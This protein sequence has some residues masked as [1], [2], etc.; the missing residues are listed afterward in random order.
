MSSNAELSQYQ[1]LVEHD[2][3][4]EQA[5][6]R[7]LSSSS[8]RVTWQIN[9]VS[10]DTVDDENE[11]YDATNGDESNIKSP[12][13]NGS[14]SD[15][16]EST[17]EEGVMQNVD[18]STTDN[19]PDSIDPIDFIESSPRLSH[20]HSMVMGGGKGGHQ[21]ENWN[22]FLS[23]RDFEELTRKSECNLVNCVHNV[24]TSMYYVSVFHVYTRA[25]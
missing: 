24:F 14:V 16:G 1:A 23:E 17:A 9:Q 2:S 20:P 22:M 15:E 19:F 21:Y 4:V 8:K 6:I 3:S 7:R 18:S 5:R 10:T 25:N 12:Q 11:V 13:I